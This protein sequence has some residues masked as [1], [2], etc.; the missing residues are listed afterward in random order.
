MPGNAMNDIKLDGQGMN[1][2]ISKISTSREGMTVIIPK[3]LNARTAR[4]D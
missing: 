2:D 3:I 4:F 1:L